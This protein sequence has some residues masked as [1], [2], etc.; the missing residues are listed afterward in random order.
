M[1]RVEG[2][3]VVGDGEG[4]VRERGLLILYGYF[5]CF[6]GMVRGLGLFF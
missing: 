6:L 2:F 3:Y 1:G 4:V 5:F